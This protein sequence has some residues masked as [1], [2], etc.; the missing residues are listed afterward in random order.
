MDDR[1]LALCE[2]SED[3]LFARIPQDRMAYYIDASLEAGRNAAVPFRGQ[4][5]R[6]LYASEHI[7]ITEK[8]NGK[9][10]CGVILRGQA[11]MGKAGCAVEVYRD[12]IRELA[13]HS[14]WQ[15][16]ALTTEQALEVHLA[17]EF[18]HILEYRSGSTVADR[19]A[20][21]ERFSLLGWKPTAHITRCCEIAAHAFAKELLGLAALPNLF[22]YLYL[23]ETGKLTQAAFEEKLTRMEAML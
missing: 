10:G 4:S 3:L 7:A 12:S 14:T 21:V 19:L 23:I 2:L 9:Q 15:G 22:D 16:V 6:A 5:I 18:F 13:A 17:H 8:G 11:V 1:I 20:P